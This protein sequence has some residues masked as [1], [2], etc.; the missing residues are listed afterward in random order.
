MKTM[1]INRYNIEC[2]IFRQVSEEN[3]FSW[4]CSNGEELSKCY[5]LVV[6]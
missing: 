2:V 4:L 6:A 5:W 1:F 3:L